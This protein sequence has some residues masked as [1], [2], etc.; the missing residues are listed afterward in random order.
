MHDIIIIIIYFRKTGVLLL[1]FPTDC[2]KSCYV[3]QQWFLNTTMHL[4][5]S[6]RD[7]VW[8]S[9]TELIFEGS[10]EACGA[11][12]EWVHVKKLL[13]E[14]IYCS[15]KKKSC[16]SL[17]SAVIWTSIAHLLLFLFLMAEC[18]SVCVRFP[19]FFCQTRRQQGRQQKKKNLRQIRI[20]FSLLVILVRVRL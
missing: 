17:S 13:E 15:L 12:T 9:W 20:V 16:V 6:A 14:G 10:H 19:L 1:P 2:S 8:L 3:T 4:F 7:C 11:G 5:W 18:V